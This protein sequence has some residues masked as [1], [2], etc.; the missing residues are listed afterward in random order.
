MPP[1]NV[2]PRRNGQILEKYNLARINQDEVEKMNGPITNT[3]I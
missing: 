2:K 1:K 3:E